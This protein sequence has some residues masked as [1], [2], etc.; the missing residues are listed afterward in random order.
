MEKPLPASTTG[1][2]FPVGATLVSGGANFSVF[3]RSAAGIT[4]C[5]SIGWMTLVLRA[6]SPLIL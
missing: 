3:S 5:F 6:L 2:S 1:R 4:C